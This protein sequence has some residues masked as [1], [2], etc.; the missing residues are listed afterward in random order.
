[1]SSGNYAPYS[2]TR[3][4][5]PNPQRI[6]SRGEDQVRQQTQVPESTMQ[7]SNWT[8]PRAM[9]A[10][11]F[12]RTSPDSQGLQN[13]EL[14]LAIG[15]PEHNLSAE[16]NSFLSPTSSSP[17]SQSPAAYQMRTETLSSRSP[18]R[19]FRTLSQLDNL[20]RENAQLRQELENLRAERD[21]TQDACDNMLT[22]LMTTQETLQETQTAI[23]G[24]DAELCALRE[25]HAAQ[26]EEVLSRDE[27]WEL[28]DLRL[29]CSRLQLEADRKDKELKQARADMH[30][31]NGSR[32][33][34]GPP[35]REALEAQER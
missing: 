19:H 16:K 8:S 4:I 33:S 18:T 21:Q 6:P 28:R 17:L 1:M 26:P 3:N 14:G 32:S 10:N 35:N 22:E 15:G 27:K 2:P 23:V 34:H 5:P 24:K 29:R 9:A 25:R 13:D 7:D 20:I 12:P 30:E 11:G 31:A